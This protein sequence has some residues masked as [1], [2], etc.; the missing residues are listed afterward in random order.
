MKKIFA[1]ILSATMLLSLASCAN[2]GGSGSTE[3]TSAKQTE[4]EANA[5]GNNDATK[6]TAAADAIVLL[7]GEL[8]QFDKDVI[9]GITLKGNQ[10]GSAEFNDK[11]PDVKGIRCVFLLN[12]WVE[13]HLDSSVTNGI[14]VYVYK[15]AD[16]AKVYTD[17]GF[18]EEDVKVLATCTLEK[19]EDAADQWGSLYL[20][21]DS[22]DPGVYDI[23]FVKDGKAVA[24]MEAKFY[25]EVDPIRDKSDDDLRAM[26]KDF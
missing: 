9:K 4:T 18:T 19:P 6:D 16:D 13:F 23:V 24:V 21:P 11:D 15:H 1:L 5:G 12:E 14:Y 26:M 7:P 3:A 10:L 22:A 25:A 8:Y 17:M 20:N 2:S